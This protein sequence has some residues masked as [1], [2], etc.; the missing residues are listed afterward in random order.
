VPSSGIVTFDDRPGQNQ[1]L[2]GQYPSGLISWGTG[3]WFHSGPWG[4]FTTKSI[5]FFGPQYTSGSFTF[6]VPRRLVAFDAYNGGPTSALVTV[7]CP[8]Q[9]TSNRN[10]AAGAIVRVYTDWT[11]PCTSVTITT[12]N[13]W[14]TNFDNLSYDSP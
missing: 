13:S 12:S 1:S 9:T 14:D 7:S 11:A 2:N 8:G 3:R 5:S 10:V 6:L 4:G